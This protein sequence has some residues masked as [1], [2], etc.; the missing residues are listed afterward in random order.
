MVR[1]MEQQKLEMQRLMEEEQRKQREELAKWMESEK[2]KLEEAAATRSQ[3]PSDRDASDA[4]SSLLQNVKTSLCEAE[5]RD[6]STRSV[7]DDTKSLLQKTPSTVRQTSFVGGK[8]Y[9]TRVMNCFS[10]YFGLSMVGG[11]EARHCELVHFVRLQ[12]H[13][14]TNGSLIL[15][16]C[17]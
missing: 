3:Q 10:S 17:A 5:S 8:R 2:S 15:I 12:M 1:A 13:Y 9:P 7:L 14:F 6:S 16:K 4:K 11:Q